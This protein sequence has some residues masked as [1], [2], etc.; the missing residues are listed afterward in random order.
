M[1]LKTVP[2]SLPIWM[3]GR[4]ATIADHR[5]LRVADLIAEGIAHVLDSDP[6]RLAELAAELKQIKSSRRA[7]T[8]PKGTK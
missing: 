1:S 8:N 5:E 6:D 3:W 2:V 4:L 7:P